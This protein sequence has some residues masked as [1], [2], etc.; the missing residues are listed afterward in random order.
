MRFNPLKSLTPERLTNALDAADA[1]WLREKA[2]ILETI[3]RRDAICRTVLGKRKDA[4]KLQPWRIDINKG[5]EENPEAKAHKATL[6]FFYENLTVTD[7]TDLNVRSDLY[8]L[9]G[10][11]L[12]AVLQTYANHEIVWE[13]GDDGVTAELRFVPLYFFENRT[14][15]LRFVGPETRADGT[16]LEEGGWM[17][18][19][20]ESVGDAISI[21]YMFRRL[22][23]Q[24]WI[25]FSEKFSIPGVVGR[26]K[27]QKGTPDG[28]AF[29][30]AVANFGSEWVGVFFNDDGSMKSPIEII[31]TVASSTLPQKEMAFY[32]DKLITVL[33]RGGDLGTLSQEDSQGA[34]LQGDETANI[35]AGD[36][37]LIS[38][39]LN[40]WLD[41]L[42][43]A[44]VHGE[45]V[46][47]LVKFVISPPADKDEKAE[48]EVDEKLDKLGVKQTP[49]D[50]AERYGREHDEEAAAA[51]EAKAKEIQGK[52]PGDQS[53][54]ISEQ[55]KAKDTEADTDAENSH[56]FQD[57]V[58]QVRGERRAAALQGI[59]TA[60]AEDLRPLGDAL[61][62]AMGAGDEAA[63]KAALRK[64]SNRM[65]EFIE[66]PALAAAMA[67]HLTEAFTGTAPTNEP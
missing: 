67:A 41:P 48:L 28:D 47:P 23:V 34:S 22:S 52:V 10:Q 42:V 4:V 63:F 65:P 37:R 51:A 45:G 56:P 17:T 26:T 58:A 27:H 31:Q 14:G 30:S 49:E 64:I 5:E 44:M 32:M 57:W 9:V 39:T 11:M 54:V 25:A 21:C 62:G 35:L 2:L 13:P 66:S 33:V 38:S 18:T 43:I 53:S 55:P 29:V 50:L 36:C 3:G 19:V 16:P 61:F 60:L 20:A 12:D 1:G 46:K 40:T 24:D 15:R 59:R 6:E 7:A 8:G